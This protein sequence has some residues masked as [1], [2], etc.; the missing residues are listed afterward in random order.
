MTYEQ[1]DDFYIAQI[2][3]PYG[4][5]FAATVWRYQE[6]FLGDVTDDPAEAF[7]RAVDTTS[8]LLPAIKA[9]AEAAS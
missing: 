5:K 7:R 8:R 2:D 9:S 1:A 3:Q 4:S 6:G